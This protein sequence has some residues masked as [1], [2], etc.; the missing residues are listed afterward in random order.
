NAT[1]ANLPALLEQFEANFTAR[2]GIIHWA[3][4]A[5]E[6]NQ[7][8]TELIRA[9]GETE[10]VKVKSMATQEIGLNEYLEAQGI[11]AFETDLA[12]LIVQLDRDKPSHILVPAIHKNRSQIREIFL[13]EMED[14]D[15]ALSNEPARLAEAARRHL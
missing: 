9:T 4:D 7:L 1:M 5:Q 10:V 13:R 15:P 8:V 3:R 14:V 12:E 2:G 11:A 6:A